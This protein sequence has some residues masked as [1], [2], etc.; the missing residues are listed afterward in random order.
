MA[1][2]VEAG[3]AEVV[4]EAVVRVVVTLVVAALGIE[5]V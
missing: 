3:L 5:G 2:M 1:A 4:K